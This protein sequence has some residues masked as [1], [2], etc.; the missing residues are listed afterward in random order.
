[1]SGRNDIVENQRRDNVARGRGA[2][3]RV[4]GDSEDEGPS[5]KENE[6]PLGEEDDDMNMLICEGEE[7]YQ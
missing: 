3:K 6:G 2:V 4:I 7:W 1:M 5:D